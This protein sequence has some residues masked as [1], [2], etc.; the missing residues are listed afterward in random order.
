MSNKGVCT[1]DLGWYGENCDTNIPP[2]PPPLS[3]GIPSSDIPL[4]G[5]NINSRIYGKLRYS[6]NTTLFISKLFGMVTRKDYYGN[7]ING[8][9]ENNFYVNYESNGNNVNY[10]YTY[11]PT[12][13]S[14]LENQTGLVFK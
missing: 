12:T 7:V 8:N 5:V 3:G 10:S 1:C 2:T 6:T 14:L 11:N 13:D 4:S 9:T